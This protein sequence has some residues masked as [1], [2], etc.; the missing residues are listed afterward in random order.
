MIRTKAANKEELLEMIAHGADRIINSTEE[1]SVSSIFSFVNVA[2][3][4]SFH[5]VF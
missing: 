1:S 5:I 2:N 4:I 3:Y